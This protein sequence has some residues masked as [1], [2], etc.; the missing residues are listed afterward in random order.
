MFKAVVIVDDF[1][2]ASENSDDYGSRD[3]KKN[4]NDIFRIEN[5]K[6]FI[7]PG[8]VF[9]IEATPPEAISILD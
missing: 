9:K 2:E 8:I 4:N 7:G 3:I 6:E 5:Q 1:I